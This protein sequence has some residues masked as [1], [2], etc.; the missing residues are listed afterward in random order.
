MRAAVAGAINYQNA[1]FLRARELEAAAARRD[2]SRVIS[3]QEFLLRKHS[4]TEAQTAEILGVSEATVRRYSYPRNG[5]APVLPSITVAGERRYRTV[6]IEAYQARRTAHAEQV[7][8]WRERCAQIRKERRAIAIYRRTAIHQDLTAITG[9]Y[10][11]GDLVYVT[12]DAGQ[13]LHRV[14]RVDVRSGRY[15][16][17]L[18]PALTDEDGVVL[19]VGRDGAHP[20]IRRVELDA[21]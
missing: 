15:S 13:V 12:T 2:A 8:A 7:E 11:R 20:K 1:I 16:V 18:D 6:D 17:S 9:P 10:R 14:V 4:R 19:Y 3:A 21:A 5:S